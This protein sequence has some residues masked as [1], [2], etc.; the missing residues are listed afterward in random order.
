MATIRDPRGMRGGCRSLSE[1]SQ[2]LSGNLRPMQAF[3]CTRCDMNVEFGLLFL[4]TE[5]YS[6]LRNSA[7]GCRR[8]GAGGEGEKGEKH[9]RL[10]PSSWCNHSR[11][12][13]IEIGMQNIGPYIPARAIK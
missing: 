2:Q 6:I 8:M 1:S 4:K 11:R 12:A 13:D 5:K 7:C 10:F 3:S 9:L